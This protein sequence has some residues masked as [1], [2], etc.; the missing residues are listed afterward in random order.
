ME[1]NN[2]FIK[3]TLLSMDIFIIHRCQVE[4]INLRVLFVL[5]FYFLVK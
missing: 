1:N 3:L 2:N 5:Y 4:N